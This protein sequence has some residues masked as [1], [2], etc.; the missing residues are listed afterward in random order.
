MSE[1]L[2]PERIKGWQ[3]VIDYLENEL[4]TINDRS[5]GLLSLK[6]IEG[7]T[8]KTIIFALKEGK[9][10]QLAK[11]SPSQK[12]DITAELLTE[13]EIF[14]EF[15]YDPH[16]STWVWDVCASRKLCKAQLAKAYRPKLK[17][18]PSLLNIWRP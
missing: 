15:G 4:A 7:I 16:S 18:V 9:E 13:E 8:L 17:S 1:I 6:A 3:D 2:K 5:A 14:K 11:C 12:E 10:A